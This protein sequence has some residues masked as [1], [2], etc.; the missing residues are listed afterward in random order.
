MKYYQTLDFLNKTYPGFGKQPG[1]YL[2]VQIN[3]IPTG[4]DFTMVATIELS[5]F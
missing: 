2:I 3:T 5:N 1:G 4:L